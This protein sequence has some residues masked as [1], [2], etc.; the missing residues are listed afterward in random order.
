M[1]FT[2]VHVR[3]FSAH[4]YSHRG[5]LDLAEYLYHTAK[6]VWLFSPIHLSHAVHTGAQY[7]SNTYVFAVNI[8]D[9]SRADKRESST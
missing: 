8:T 7:S 4:W 6:S 3:R 9:D 1:T 2:R 5:V